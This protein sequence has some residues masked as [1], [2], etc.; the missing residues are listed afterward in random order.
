MSIDQLPEGVFAFFDER[1]GFSPLIWAENCLA[2]I[3]AMDIAFT[4]S[5]HRK[6]VRMFPLDEL[7]KSSKVVVVIEEE[8]LV[9]FKSPRSKMVFNGFFWYGQVADYVV[10]QWMEETGTFKGKSVWK[11]GPIRI[12]NFD[13]LE[14]VGFWIA[15]EITGERAITFM[16]E[17]NGPVIAFLVLGE[18]KYLPVAT[19][20]GP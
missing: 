8:P 17:K 5:D 12:K 20:Y 10:A 14:E 19:I 2:A 16:R 11:Q 13:T 3:Q 4:L 9:F 15:R 18:D 7:G 6:A 1:V